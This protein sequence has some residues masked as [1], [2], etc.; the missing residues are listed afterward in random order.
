MASHSS[1]QSPS[2]EVF[3]CLE[4]DLSLSTVE[5]ISAVVH[6][7]PDLDKGPGISAPEQV[8]H[9]TACPEESSLEMAAGQMPG[10][11]PTAPEQVPHQLTG[12]GETP[13]PEQTTH[14]TPTPG[15]LSP[16]SLRQR[17]IDSCPNLCCNSLFISSCQVTLNTTDP[18]TIHFADRSWSVNYPLLSFL[19]NG[20]LYADYARVTG[21]LG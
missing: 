4:P 20:Q 2:P 1:E 15:V 17:V 21:M 19:M 13:V 9:Q 5:Q 14:Q 8:P 12:S 3:E 11:S 18:P 7:I 16:E 6:Q 10:P